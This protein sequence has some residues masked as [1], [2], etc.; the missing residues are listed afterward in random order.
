MWLP[1][2]RYMMGGDKRVGGKDVLALELLGDPQ[3]APGRPQTN[4]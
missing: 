4:C 1:F 3:N 2:T